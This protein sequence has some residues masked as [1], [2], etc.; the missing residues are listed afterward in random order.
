MRKLLV[1]SY[2]LLVVGLLAGCATTT[3][4]TTK[5]SVYYPP[6]CSTFSA[7]G[8]QA[9][10]EKGKSDEAAR[11]QKIR[12]M[13]AYNYGKTGHYGGYNNYGYNNYSPSNYWPILSVRIKTWSY[14]PKNWSNR[15]RNRHHKHNRPPYNYDYNCNGFLRYTPHCN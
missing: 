14:S 4:T 13:A 1:V 2:W 6:D 3:A 7:S 9:A 5:G 10:C 12:E 8:E 11:V 15:W